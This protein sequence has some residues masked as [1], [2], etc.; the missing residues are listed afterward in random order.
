MVSQK[1]EWLSS[2]SAV[3]DDNDDRK[4]MRKK[5]WKKTDALRQLSDV[6][7]KRHSLYPFY[8]FLTSRLRNYRRKSIRRHGPPPARYVIGVITISTITRA[9]WRLDEIAGAHAHIVITTHK[10]AL[11]ELVYAVYAARTGNA[12]TQCL[13]TTDGRFWSNIRSCY[14]Q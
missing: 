12:R 10:R 6:Y 9:W 5:K 4:R 1:W 13:M 7:S 14:L 3:G 2:D 11:H 8:I